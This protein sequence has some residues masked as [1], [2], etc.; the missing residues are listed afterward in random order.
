MVD[1]LSRTNP[2]FARFVA[3][4]RGKTPEQIASDYGVDYSLVRQLASR[5]VG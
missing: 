2:Q 5:F 4:N 3:E 1:R